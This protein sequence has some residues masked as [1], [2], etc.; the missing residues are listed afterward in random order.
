MF[1]NEMFM[2]KMCKVLIH[3]KSVLRISAIFIMI[4]YAYA[5]KKYSH[6]WM[7]ILYQQ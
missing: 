2:L 3:K 1:C 5:Y 7:I 6:S 4:S